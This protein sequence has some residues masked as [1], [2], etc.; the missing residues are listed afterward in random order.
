MNESGSVPFLAKCK[1]YR[2]IVV[3][4]DGGRRQ[5]VRLTGQGR[6]PTC[7]VPYTE[8]ETALRAYANGEESRQ[9]SFPE[10][11]RPTSGLVHTHIQDS[12]QCYVGR[13]GTQGFVELRRD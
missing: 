8:S 5:V 6:G 2:T 11:C 1:D 9:Y 3:G 13:S 7:S 10:Q 4:T 12:G